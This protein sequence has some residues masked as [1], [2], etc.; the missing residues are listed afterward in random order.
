MSV[1]GS[2]LPGG[3]ITA[4]STSA[5]AERA[6]G[7]VRP[8][9]TFTLTGAPLG[10]VRI[11]VFAERRGDEPFVPVPPRYADPARS[12]LACDVPAGGRRGLAP[13]LE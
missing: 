12:P 3:T 1:N 4:V 2:P 8:N 11:G 9:G 10:E 6:T 5:P 7:V 13:E